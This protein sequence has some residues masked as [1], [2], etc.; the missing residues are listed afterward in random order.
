MTGPLPSGRSAVAG[1]DA[2]Q[3]EPHGRVGHLLRGL[4]APVDELTRE[5]AGDTEDAVGDEGGIAIAYAP[6]DDALLDMANEVVDGDVLSP[7]KCG[8]EALFGRRELDEGDELMVLARPCERGADALLDA[9]DGVVLVGDGVH[10][11][12][13]EVLLGI[14]QYLEE[15]LLL[16]GEVPVEDALAHAE[17]ADDLL[18]GGRVVAALGEAGGGVVHQLAPSFLPPLGQPPC[19]RADGRQT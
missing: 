9:P 2:L 15:E 13:S 10:L 12:A 8:G 3:A 5:V 1:E 18:D 6:R 7:P 17:A 11:R 14:A 16:R 19:H 4:V